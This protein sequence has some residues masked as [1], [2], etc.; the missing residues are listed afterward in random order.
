MKINFANVVLL[1]IL[2]SFSSAFSDNVAGVPTPAGKVLIL[3]NKL[4][5]G[6]EFSE[7]AMLT[8]YSALTGDQ[9]HVNSN[10]NRTTANLPD[11]SIPPIT[12]APTVDTLNITSSNG[13]FSNLNSRFGTQI[14]DSLKGGKELLYWDLVFDLRF[15]NTASAGVQSISLGTAPTS[16]INLYQSFLTGGGGLFIQAEYNVF[17]SRNSGV[18][19]LV[20]MFTRENFDPALISPGSIYQLT[21]SSYSSVPENFNKDFNDL[22]STSLEQPYIVMGGTYPLSGIISGV[23]LIKWGTGSLLHLWDSKDLVM[24][25]GRFMV[26]FD[27]NAW[28]DH[29][30]D[31]QGGK[32]TRATFAFIQNIYDLISGVKSYS[33]SKAF[34]PEEIDV[35]Q[36]GTFTISIENKKD[37]PL[38]GFTVT[39]TVSACLNVISANPTWTSRNGNVFTW[40]V[41]E[42]L[43][44]ST[45]TITVQYSADQMPPCN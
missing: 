18:T 38:Y 24:Q 31:W 10:P 45:K 6:Y 41:D 15:A 19:A 34:I 2:F 43:G 8:F 21:P 28:G 22:T 3:Y 1:T 29:Q 7:P 36:N 9:S 33:V 17:T 4:G 12:P 32:V 5:F 13:I 27:I 11:G 14:P 40:N 23:P 30:T 44:R 39:D 20:N 16:D 42:V 26:S 37:N 25:D 35:G